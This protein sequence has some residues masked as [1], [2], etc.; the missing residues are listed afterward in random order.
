MQTASQC[1]FTRG[2]NNWRAAQ[3]IL[4]ITL[5]FS[6]CQASAASL[7]AGFSEESI[8]GP[9]SDPVGL[10]FEPEQQEP[11]GRAYVWERA[12][13]VWIVES[14]AKLP[15]PLIDI[16]E[17]VGGWRDFGLLG[18]AFDP[19][20]R[21]N[22][23]IYLAYTVDH[24]HLTKF[25][26]VAYNSATNEYFMATIHRVTRYTAR[27]AD[28]FSTVDPAS[29]KILL[30][31]SITNGFPVTYQSHGIGSIVFGTDGTLLVACGDGASYTTIDTGSAPETYY[32]QAMAEGII[33]TNENV[34]ALRAQMLSSLSGKIL[35]LDPATGNGVPSNPFFDAAN[36]RSARS[37]VWSLGLRNPYRMTLRPGT[38]S[39]DP[40]DANPGVL[41]IG[42]VGLHGFEDLNVAT[43][44]GQNFGWPLYEGLEAHTTYRNRNVG[45][46]DAPNPLFGIGGCTQPYFYFRDL[47]V[48][49]TLN[50][51]SWP[52]PCNPAQQVPSS[53]DRFVHRRPVIDWKHVNGPARTGIYAAN[54]T[55]AVTNIGGP[56][57]PVSGPQFGGTSSIGGTWYQGDDFPVMYK[58]SYFHGDYEG[59]WIRNFTFDAND[60]PIAVR[61]F[62]TNGS[63]IKRVSYG[64]GA[65]QA[66]RAVATADQFYGSSPLTVQFDGSASTDPE[67]FPLTYSWDFGD[68]SPVNTNASPLHT[69]TAPEGV[70]TSFTVTLTL[71]DNSNATAQ[72]T[73][74]ISAN[75]TPPTV[76]ITSPTNGTR[77]PLNQETIYP[78]TATISDAEHD[79]NQLKC[80]WLTTLHHNNHVHTDPADTNCTSTVSI[81][82]L[83][84]DG[85]TY[86]YTIALKV[87]DA[88]GLATTREVRLDPDCPAL[89]PSLTFLGRD[90]LGLIRWQLIG[91]PMRTYVVEGSTN[92]A[93]WI[94]VTSIT[95][96]TGSEEFTDAVAGNLPYRFYR[97]VLSP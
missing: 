68:S 37:R 74:L 15:Q 8:P 43:A 93:D 38:G 9:W 35:R 73:L 14:G 52:N 87:T 5:A 90:G 95:P 3:L 19:Q 26:T 61:N 12:G 27:A 4:V 55:A 56:G 23:Y 59:Q 49:D 45:N 2:T 54:G 53:F 1:P 62:L 48:Q 7:P 88:A 67:G 57:S 81:A 94:P 25:G 11:G 50:S 97:A 63:G 82:P 79:A 21:Q 75:N 29:R 47:C 85:Q 64:V 22:G 58:N 91:D 28:G 24:H 66:P 70:P 89:A 41:Y 36:P 92:L 46:P 34:G 86:Y 78:L 31:E 40:A 51:L 69:F 44:P 72:A 80:S 60:K 10:T 77:Y 83:G 96:S 16:V 71:R 65:N 6:L 32:L 20:F 30:G 18:F 76:N 33:R 84:C 13:R 39:H 42:D 17:E